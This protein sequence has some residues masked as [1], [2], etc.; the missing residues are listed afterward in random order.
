MYIKIDR[1]LGMAPKYAPRELGP[2][3]SQTAKDAKL[4]SKELRS[5]VK[6]LRVNTPSKTGTKQ[7]IYLL[8]GFWL[9]WITDVDVAR[10]PIASDLFGR[11]YYTGDKVPKVTNSTLVQNGAGTDYPLDWYQLGVP[12]PLN[13]ASLVVTGGGAPVVTRSYVYTYVTQWGEEGKPSPT[14]SLTG[15]EDGSW[16]LSAMDVAP[17]NN[18]VVSGATHSSGVVTVTVT[19]D[20]LLRVGEYVTIASV[21]GMTDLNAQWKVNTVPSS[22]TFTVLLTTAQT[23]TSGGTWE[24][25]SNINVTTMVKRIYRTLSGVFTFVAEIAVATTTYSDT[26]ADAALGEKIPST[27]WDMPPTDMIGIL[28]LPNG[29]TMGFRSNELIFSEPNFPHAYPTKY[30]LATD[31]DVVAVGAYGNNVAVG[32]KGQPYLVIGT[33]PNNMSMTRIELKHACVSK[34][35]MLNI[36]NGILYASPEGLVYIGIGG[37]RLLTAEILTKDEWKL[38]NPGSVIAQRYDDRY[39]GC[40]SGA[41]ENNDES[42]HFVLDPDEAD[43]LFVLGGLQATGG[44]SDIETDDMY[45]VEDGQII[46]WEA[47]GEES[48]ANWKSKV[49]ITPNP[50]A[51]NAGQA[52]LTFHGISQATFNAAVAAGMLGV[53]ASR[54]LSGGANEQLPSSG[55]FAGSTPGTYTVAGGPYLDVVNGLSSPAGVTMNLYAKGA[56]VH[57]QQILDEEPFR[58]PGDDTYETWEIEM[59]ANKAEVHDVIVAETMSELA[60]V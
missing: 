18:G 28:I 34:R 20:H 45:L 51:F 24:R 55:A 11:H 50:L 31:W 41:G 42:G 10:S 32:T 1:F 2:E 39:Y 6:P 26:I 59:S 35:S 60:E 57:T 47:G 22:T 36:R 53:D 14:V 5:I 46:Q 29:I 56:L 7:S 40:Y 27:D 54:L 43:N 38:Y 25:E 12:S 37:S 33:H 44:Y 21:V 4:W 48:Q 8:A 19:A 3:Q 58:I 15:N 17:L 16:D 9:H 30:R 23:Y 13:A 49:F 52:H